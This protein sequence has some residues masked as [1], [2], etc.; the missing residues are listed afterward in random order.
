MINKC[1]SGG[2]W[3]HSQ[4]FVI[5]Y[6]AFSAALNKDLCI[7]SFAF[8]WQHLHF[9]VK[10][11]S[12]NPGRWYIVLRGLWVLKFCSHLLLEV[13]QHVTSETADLASCYLLLPRICLLLKWRVPIFQLPLTPWRYLL[14][15]PP[16]FFQL[17][18]L[19]QPD[20]LQCCFTDVIFF[21]FVLNDVFPTC[22]VLVQLCLETNV[23]DSQMAIFPFAESYWEHH[24][25]VIQKTA[26]QKD[27]S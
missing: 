26:H 18:Y 15:F 13:L 4:S 21:P 23:W 22:W 8:C 11:G 25:P 2:L 7:S 3:F 27:F 1:T 20:E 19:T 9:Q 10:L 16:G 24:F 17:F 14:L 5:L 6:F 12:L